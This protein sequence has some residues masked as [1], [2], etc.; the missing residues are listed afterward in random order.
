[1]DETDLA[2]LREL[3]RDQVG[4]WGRLDPRVSASEIARHVNLA[5]STVSTRLKRWHETGLLV[6]HDLWPNPGLFDAVFTAGTVRVSQPRRKPAVLEG[7]TSVEG[8]AG[9]LDHVGP[10][11]GIAL[12]GQR[13]AGLDRTERVIE[14]LAGV[15]GTE[16]GPLFEPPRCPADLSELDWRIIAASKVEPLGPDH[17]AAERAG[18]STRTY[19]RRYRQMIEENAL[20][21]VLQMDFRRWT[22]GAL[23]R[24]FIHLG[25]DADRRAVAEHVQDILPPS[26]FI[27]ASLRPEPEVPMPMLD[28]VTHL[29]S[30]SVADDHHR[31]LL[32]V[33]AIDDVE[34][35]FPRRLITVSHWLEDRLDQRVDKA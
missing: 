17:A 6:S 26:M 22:G 9:I 13:P 29:D 11:I 10:W 30:V 33:D 18:V 3:A 20:M 27:N 2:I 12:V 35:L 15:D 14:R 31:S 32:E 34:V 25:S 21:L 7:L 19:R 1:M 28:T 5:R 16:M 4:G 24:F 23:A 8:V